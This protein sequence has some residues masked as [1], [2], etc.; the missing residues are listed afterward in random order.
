VCALI[1]VRKIIA[2][3]EVI[4]LELV[5]HHCDDGFL[6]KDVGLALTLESPVFDDGDTIRDAILAC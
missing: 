3:L 5:G 6:N 1:F 4:I 2:H